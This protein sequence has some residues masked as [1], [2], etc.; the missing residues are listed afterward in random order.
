MSDWTLDAEVDELDGGVEGELEGG[1]EGELDGGVDE[2]LEGAFEVVGVDLLA[3]I[4]EHE[5]NTSDIKPNTKA[6][7]I[8]LEEL[9]FGREA[10]VKT[11][12][13]RRNA[14]E[15]LI[16]FWNLLELD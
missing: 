7:P 14:E 4:D 16:G 8:L 9:V 10:I 1:V 6:I 11:H 13:G 3:V 5:L 2:V 12:K 15:H